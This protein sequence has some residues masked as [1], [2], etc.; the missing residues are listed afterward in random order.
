MTTFIQR[1]IQRWRP[2]GKAS[3][4]QPV[5]PVCEADWSVVRTLRDANETMGL[6]EN[7][8]V[9]EEGHAFYIVDDSGMKPH[10]FSVLQDRRFGTFLQIEYDNTNQKI[11]SM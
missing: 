7:A 1:P 4:H 8:V 3:K 11:A 2:E 9:C 6:L 10:T 5:C